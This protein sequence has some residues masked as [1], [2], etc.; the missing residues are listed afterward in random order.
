[1]PGRVLRAQLG[2]D[3]RHTLPVR[4]LCAA[5]IRRTHAMSRWILRGIGCGRADPMPGRIL[6]ASGF[7]L[8][9]SLSGGNLR[10]GGIG[11]A[12]D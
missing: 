2:D 1:M 5:R 10:T 4:L 11:F 6:R 8:A 7:V 12:H 9:D 3:F